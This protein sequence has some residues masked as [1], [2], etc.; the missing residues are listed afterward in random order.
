M[1]KKIKI[2]I[3]N[4]KLNI[5]NLDRYEKLHLIQARQELRK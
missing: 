5:V 3:I 2:T 1:I 4:L